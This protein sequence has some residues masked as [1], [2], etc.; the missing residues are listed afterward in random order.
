MKSVLFTALTA[1]F[2][3]A[4][5]LAPAANSIDPALVGTW[6]LE[7]QGSDIFW[8][9]R[10]DGVYRMHGPGAK[11]RQLGRIEASQGRF[12]MKSPLWIDSGPYELSNVDTLVITGQLGPGTWRR[13][14]IP[15]KTNSQEPAGPYACGLLAADEVARVLRAPVTG[16]PDPRAGQGGCTFRSQLGS[17]DRILISVRQNT[18]GFFQNNRKS[19]GDSVV[20]VP[21]VGD[22]AY[23]ERTGGNDLGRLQLLRRDLWVTIEAGLNPQAT[24]DDLPYLVEL[25]SAADRRLEGFSLPGPSD[26]ARKRMEEFEKAKAGGWKGRLPAGQSIP[27]QKGPKP[28]K[29]W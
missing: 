12:S 29:G 5:E 22:Q 7:W 24:M 19:K 16:G 26:S 6:K 21:G 2:M 28:F 15:T 25:A 4:A 17:L 27:P 18:A 14:W 3:V 13:V 8:A 1:L 10:S 9:I 11:A 23:A 20:N